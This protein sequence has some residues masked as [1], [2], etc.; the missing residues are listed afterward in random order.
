MIFDFSIAPV[1][2]IFVDF[3]SGDSAFTAGPVFTGRVS[4]SN[5]DNGQGL[6]GRLRPYSN[7]ARTT[8]TV[9]DC[10]FVVFRFTVHTTVSRFASTGFFLLFLAVNHVEG[11]SVGEVISLSP[12]GSSHPCSFSPVISFLIGPVTETG[13]VAPR[14][15]AQ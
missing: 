2:N 3:V 12:A 8:N 11:W 5:I 15:Q 13:P 10:I 1:T 6:F 14:V 9:V 7:R 4:F